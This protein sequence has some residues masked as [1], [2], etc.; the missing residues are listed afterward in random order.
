MMLACI[1]TA[2][3]IVI[4]GLGAIATDQAR[5]I[6]DLTADNRA[7]AEDLDAAHARIGELARERAD[8]IEV[9]PAT[10]TWPDTAR[11][12]EAES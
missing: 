7:F 8:H 10:L 12:I 9:C 6:R 5:D 3:L 2:V 11:E 1:I 4:A